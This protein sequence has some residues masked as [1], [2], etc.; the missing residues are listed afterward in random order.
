MIH[1]VS[2]LKYE[3][4]TIRKLMIFPFE[5]LKELHAVFFSLYEFNHNDIKDH[6]F[7]SQFNKIG[8]SFNFDTNNFTYKN[9]KLHVGWNDLKK[10]K[11]I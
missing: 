2:K 9:R 4:E 11:I 6:D 1:L 7:N 8:R 10:L 3:E 5:N